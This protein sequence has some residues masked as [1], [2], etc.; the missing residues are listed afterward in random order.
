MVTCAE[1]TQSNH[2]VSKPMLLDSFQAHALDRTLHGL[3]FPQDGFL[4]RSRNLT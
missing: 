3:I 1:I 4:F 2:A